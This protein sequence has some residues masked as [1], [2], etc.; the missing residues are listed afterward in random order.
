MINARGNRAGTVQAPDTANTSGRVSTAELVDFVK[1]QALRRT[2]AE[3]SRL[4][5]LS[6]K[7]VAN[8]RQGLA[9]ASAQ[10]VS[11][12]C[13]NDPLFR[14]EYFFW[15]GGHIEGCRDPD[16]IAGLTIALNSYA[17]RLHEN[18]LPRPRRGETRQ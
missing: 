4:T 11:T 10:T 1:E 12:W 8:I 2:I 16:A 6:E 9:G 7:A 18:G 14:A 17:R 5:G 13:R 15:V 3:V